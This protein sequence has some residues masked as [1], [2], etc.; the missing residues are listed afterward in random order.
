MFFLLYKI[1][2]SSMTL[3][4]NSSRAIEHSQFFPVHSICVAHCSQLQ[5]AV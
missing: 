2:V 1:T 3:Q 4:T 5:I